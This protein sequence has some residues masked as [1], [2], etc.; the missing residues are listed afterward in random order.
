MLVC[1]FGND[2][3][4]ITLHTGKAILV[5]SGTSQN[6]ASREVSWNVWLLKAVDAYTGRSHTNDRALKLHTYTSP[7]SLRQ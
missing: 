6:G 5:A 7:E 4:G 2:R 3:P 1:A